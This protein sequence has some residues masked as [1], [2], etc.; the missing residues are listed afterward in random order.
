M[1]RNLK[2]KVCPLCDGEA[3]GKPEDYNSGILDKVTGSQI[4]VEGILVYYCQNE[5]CRNSWL[6]HEQEQRIDNFIAKAKRFDLN[7]EEISL[8]RKSLAF[9]TKSEASNFLCFNEKAF[10]KWE[11]G[12]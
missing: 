6:P 7:S 9:S 2:K 10:T 5:P 4:V 12:T 11:K 1:S 8:M 3:I